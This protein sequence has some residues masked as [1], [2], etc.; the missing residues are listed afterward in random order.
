MTAAASIEGYSSVK[1][2]DETVRI[3]EIPGISGDSKQRTVPYRV[4]DTENEDTVIKALDAFVPGF[5]G[6]PL[7]TFTALQH[8]KVDTWTISAV[9]ADEDDS[10]AKPAEGEWTFNWELG[11]Q[12]VRILSANTVAVWPAAGNDA[13]HFK[14]LINVGTDGQPQGLDIYA[15]QL[16]FSID[17]TLSSAAASISNFLLLADKQLDIHSGPAFLGIFPTGSVLFLGAS[18]RMVVGKASTIN[19]KF[20]YQKNQTTSLVVQ[21]ITVDDKDGW[22]YL[23]PAYKDAIASGEQVPQV[24]ALYIARPYPIRSDLNDLLVI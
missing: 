15:K 9:Y 2:G 5:R 3:A 21:G 13:D 12:N 16:N 11:T 8:E 20:A 17:Y 23:W 14:G 4:L 19:L 10:P 1:I 22:D 7:S 24:E 18:G 6:F